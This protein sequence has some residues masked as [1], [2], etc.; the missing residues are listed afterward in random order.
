MDQ[1]IANPN[2]RRDPLRHPWSKCISVGRA[3]ELLRADLQDHLRF[4]KRELGF[5]HIRFHASFHDDVNVV[6]RAADGTL[7]YRWTQLDHIYDFLVETGFEPVVEINPMPKALASGEKT[8]FW[9]GMNVTPPASY[10]EWE[11]FIRAWVTHITERYGADR[12]RRW[13]FEVWNEPDL[14]GSFWTGTMEEYYRLYASCARVLKSFDP[15]L[16]VGGPATAAAIDQVLPFAKWCRENNVPVDFL[17][18]HNYPQNEV[19][20]Y[21]SA[22]ESSHR[23]GMYFVDR[24]RETKRRLQDEGF[25][26]L[27]L[28]MTEW[29]TQAQNPD[30]KAKWVGNEHVNDLF[31]GAAVCHLA[32]GC[33]AALDMMGFW[34]ASD[35]FEE[36]GPQLEPYGSRYQYYGMLTVDGLP[37]ASYHA[38]SFLGRLRGPR[39]ALTLPDHSPETHGAVVTDELS[40]TRALVWNC[41]FPTGD[42]RSWDLSLSLPVPPPLSGYNEIRLTTATVRAGQGSAWEFWKAM[43]APATLTR[44]EQQALAARS[45]PAWTSRMMSVTD[46]SV[47]VELSLRPNEFAFLELGGDP[48]GSDATHS[49]ALQRLNEDLMT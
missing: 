32:H 20:A 40:A 29:N 33:D 49:E 48:A 24:V 12:V 23:P 26:T 10:D 3:Y 45:T 37:K 9:Y 27:P 6:Q 38:F 21:P 41:A 43:G 39:Y 7:T 15:K 34:V 47:T 8:M 16:R 18:Y 35:V 19:G 30:W 28:F 31:S 36:G 4:L 13:Y 17:S 25:G 2:E 11:A 14:H 44:T 46:G 1:I 42:A 22:A 5:T